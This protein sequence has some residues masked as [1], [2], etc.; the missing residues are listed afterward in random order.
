LSLFC[1]AT[2]VTRPQTLEHEVFWRRMQKIKNDDD[3]QWKWNTKQEKR[4]N[5]CENK[6]LKP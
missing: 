2:S 3:E 4:W 5:H 6:T 1:K